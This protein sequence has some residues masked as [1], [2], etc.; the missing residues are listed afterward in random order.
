MQRAVLNTA[1]LQKVGAPASLGMRFLSS[2]GLIIT[3]SGYLFL[4]LTKKYQVL[5][6]GPYLMKDIDRLECDQED[7]L[8]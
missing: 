1:M 7:G 2:L 3:S 5:F 4:T 8:T 6:W